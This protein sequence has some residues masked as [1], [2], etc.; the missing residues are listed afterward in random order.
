[1]QP[2]KQ[3]NNQKDNLTMS[4]SHVVA[5]QKRA[6]MSETRVEGNSGGMEGLLV[7]GAWMVTY[8][9]AVNSLEGGT[10]VSGKWKIK[11]MSKCCMS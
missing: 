2:N 1:M 6:V 5:P 4:L 3:T 9:V 11:W 8:W 7:V 10:G